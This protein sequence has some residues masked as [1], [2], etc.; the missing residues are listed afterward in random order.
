MNLVIYSTAPVKRVPPLILQWPRRLLMPP[1][2]LI[3][4]HVENGALIEPVLE[5]EFN[6]NIC[7]QLL[8]VIVASLLF[9]CRYQVS[10]PWLQLYHPSR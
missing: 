7:L 6:Q 1:L 10:E 9:Y 2:N 5:E 8:C 3:H 4:C